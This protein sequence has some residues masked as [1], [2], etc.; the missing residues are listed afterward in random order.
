MW[1][2]PNKLSALSLCAILGFPSA[3]EAQEFSVS[4][5]RYSRTPQVGVSAPIG[6]NAHLGVRYVNGRVSASYV[7]R[8][9]SYPT[10]HQRVWVP[11]CYENR[12]QR[13]WVPAT[14]QRVWI[15]PVYETRYDPCGRPIR[16]LV[17]PGCT[18]W[19]TVPGHYQTK[20]VRVWV[21]GHYAPARVGV[22]RY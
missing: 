21:P 10:S 11:G 6:S 20:T 9:T 2:I 17:R 22:R 7:R 15:E 12:E 19:Q 4:L 18:Q 5:G 16:V 1:K 3:A 14:R 13:V 8:P